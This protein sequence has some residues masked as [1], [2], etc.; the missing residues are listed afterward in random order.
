MSWGYHSN[1]D[2]FNFDKDVDIKVDV[3]IDIE[4]DVD[5]EVKKDVDIDVDIKSDIDLDGNYAEMIFDIQAIGDD[6][7][8]EFDVAVLTVDNELS[9][10]TGHIIST[11][12]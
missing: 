3:E 8:V 1:D 5:V 9:S 12:D 10:I 2:D 7:L 11:T 4:A 6:T